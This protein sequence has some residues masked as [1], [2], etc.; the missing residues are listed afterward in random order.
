MDQM[1]QDILDFVREEYLEDDRVLTPQT[2]LISSG[3]VDS[4][5]MAS[6]KVFLEH[7]YS[8]RIPD[9]RATAQAFDSAETISE[10]VRELSGE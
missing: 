10:L 2:R 5:S 7:K 3:I 8:L 6:L 1:Q 4:F 9:E